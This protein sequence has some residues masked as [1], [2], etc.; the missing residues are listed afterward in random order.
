MSIHPTAIVD[1]SAE[2]DPSCE[3]GP[4]SVVGPGVRLAPGVVLRP[5]AYVTGRTEIG[6]GSEVF[7]FA[8]LGEIPQDM[9]Y[10]G[11]KTRLV[12]GARNQIR[13]YVTIHIGTSHGGGTTTVGDNNMLMIG[14]H[15]GHDSQIGS[16]V[17]ISNGVQLAGHVIVEDHATIS[18]HSAVLQFCRLGESSFLAGMSGLMQD[19]APF[20]WGQG[21]P[22][23][24]VR[25]NRLN[26]ERRGFSKEQMDAVER[27]FRLVFRSGRLPEEAF[28]QVREELPESGEA[29]HL[30][31]FLE[32]KS[33]RGFARLR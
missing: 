14:T 15:I 25:V 9:K 28:A 17:V 18:A 3:I 2:V 33:D 27:A 21:Y 31:A 32:K 16:H 10:R 23:R 8:C 19:L 7:S 4:Y 30:I 20:S 29:E 1:S 12:V 11:E 5:H 22:A 6:S 13:E 24:V 26:L